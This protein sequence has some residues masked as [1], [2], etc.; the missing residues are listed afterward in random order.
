[1]KKIIAVLLALLLTSA[2][3]TSCKQ[4]D[5]GINNADSVGTESTQ[6][7]TTV[8]IGAN[9]TTADTAP[10]SMNGDEFA[11]DNEATYNDAWD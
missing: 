2:L 8:S 5:D 11:N 3:L 7:D 6:S 1:M 10:E 9:E 4:D